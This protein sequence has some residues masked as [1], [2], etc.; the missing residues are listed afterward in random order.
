MHNEQIVLSYEEL[1]IKT[2]QLLN[3]LKVPENESAILTDTLL[4]AEIRGTYSHGLIRLPFY[5]KRILSG[6]IKVPTSLDIVKEKEAVSVIDGNDGLGTTISHFAMVK[7]ISKAKKY[8]VGISSVRNSQHFGTAGYYANLAT[9]DDMIG[10]VFTNASP[11]LA[12]WGGVDTMLGNNPWSIA[13]PTSDPE[14]PFVLDLSNSIVAAGKIRKAAELGKTIPDGW[15]LDSQGNPTNDPYEALR[16]VLLP[17]GMHKGYGITLAISLLTSGLSDGVWDI[18]VNP[19]D[20]INK[21]QRVSH[22]FI[23]INIDFFLDINKFKSFI[24]EKIVMLRNSKKVNGVEKI[25]FPGERGGISRKIA[26]KDGVKLN[27]NSFKEV[28]RIA[29]KY[30]L[31]FL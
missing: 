7:A 31:N 11:R 3:H 27:L 20:E 28:M 4:D 5:E 12:P 10:L 1:T 14:L 6:A 26:L 9:R 18:D 13:L 17:M 29:E 23:A 15:A 30:N 8:G 21:T 25:F 24:E 19:I 2:K 22:L 16:G